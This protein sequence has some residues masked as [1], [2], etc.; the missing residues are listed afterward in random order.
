[1][2][3]SLIHVLNNPIGLSSCSFL[4]PAGH[5]LSWVVS[6]LS[7]SP[8]SPSTQPTNPPSS[9]R[10]S[11]FS[12]ILPNKPNYL[13]IPSSLEPS[14]LLALPSHLSRLDDICEAVNWGPTFECWMKTKKQTHWSLIPHPTY[15]RYCWRSLVTQDIVTANDS[16]HRVIRFDYFSYH[17]SSSH[18]SEPRVRGENNIA[19]GK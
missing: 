13:K 11:N 4:L 15:R 2:P 5:L 16:P 10:T 7:A 1:M 3:L 18:V 6:L 14:F 8:C 9:F 17:S 19:S 12:A